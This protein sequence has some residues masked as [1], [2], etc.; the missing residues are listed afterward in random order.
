MG[1]GKEECL[2]RLI[3]LNIINNEDIFCCHDN[4]Y[5]RTVGFCNNFCK[6]FTQLHLCQRSVLTVVIR[7]RAVQLEVVALSKMQL[8][9]RN[10]T[11]SNE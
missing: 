9:K 2:K 6:L 3:R 10:I 8:S 5:I 4:V 1:L 11:K 7:G